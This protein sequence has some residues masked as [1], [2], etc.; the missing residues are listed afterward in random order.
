MQPAHLQ[1][2]S[3]AEPG[4]DTF[5][6]FPRMDL[7]RIGRSQHLAG[8]LTQ[9]GNPAQFTRRQPPRRDLD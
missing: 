8:G 7:R 2:W 4:P 5:H 1:F 3:G 9:C 6:A